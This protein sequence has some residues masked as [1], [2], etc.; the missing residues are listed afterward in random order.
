MHFSNG[1]EIQRI[2][3]TVRALSLEATMAVE[4]DLSE[5][6]TDAIED[7]RDVDTSPTDLKPVV[8]SIPADRPRPA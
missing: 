2:A 3:L 8:L 6:F 1:Y 5:A 4:D 7:H